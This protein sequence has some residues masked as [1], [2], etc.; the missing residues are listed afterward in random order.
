[1]DVYA[2]V[3]VEDAD[4]GPSGQIRSLDIIDGDPDGY[5]RVQKVTATDGTGAAEYNIAV[6]KLLD[7]ERAPSGYNLTLR[8]V[9]SGFPPRNSTA[10]LHVTVADWNDH[11]PVFDREHYEVSIV[12]TAPVGTPLIR[13]RVTDQDQGRNA[14]VQLSIVGG[15]QGGHFRINPT[16]G[17]LYTAHPLDA[18]MRTEHVLTVSAIDQGTAGTRKQSSAKVTVRV[19]DA[20]DNDPIFYQQPSGTLEVQVSIP[21]PLSAFNQSTVNV[22]IREGTPFRS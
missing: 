13:L 2:V 7:R 14:L 21:L 4:Q 5:F 16:S 10:T 22:A 20:N 8:A 1:M 18:E 9:D 19:M 15:N 6:L 12:E 3:R 17:V 11:A